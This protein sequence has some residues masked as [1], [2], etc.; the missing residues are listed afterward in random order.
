MKLKWRKGRI[1]NAALRNSSINCI[2]L[3]RLPIQDYSKLSITKKRQNKT[4][5]E[6][7]GEEDLTLWRRPVCKTLWKALEISSAKT[8]SSKSIKNP[9]NSIRYNCH[10]IYSW[11]RWPETILEIRNKV[12]FLEVI[13]KPIIYTFFK[14]STNQRRGTNT[15]LVYCCIYLSLHSEILGPQM[16]SSNNL[17]LPNSQNY[18]WILKSILQLLQQINVLLNVIH[19]TWY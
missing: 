15:G 9:S 13:K 5:Y 6:I 16:R 8:N 2:F 19:N 18:L 17:D 7:L 10:K 14:D 12:T 11:M 4:K 3:R 1:N